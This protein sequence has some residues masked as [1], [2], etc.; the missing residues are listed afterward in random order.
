MRAGRPSRRGGRPGRMAGRSSCMDRRPS[1]MAGRPPCL[2]PLAPPQPFPHQPG[3][4]PSIRTAFVR[5]SCCL[6]FRFSK[7]LHPTLVVSG[8]PLPSFAYIN[9]HHSPFKS[10]PN[11]LEKF[12]KRII[13]SLSI[14]WVQA[15]KPEF[16]LGGLEYSRTP[17]SLIFDSIPLRGGSFQ[18]NSQEGTEGDHP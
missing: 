10:T 5:V 8:N 16:F 4:N 2:G 12:S 7:T 11:L 14:T 1:C 9:P 13:L 6:L 17:N 3:P 18:A 15:F